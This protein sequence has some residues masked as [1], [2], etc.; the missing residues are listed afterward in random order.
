MRNIFYYNACYY[1]LV[2]RLLYYQKIRETCPKCEKA[3]EQVVE[4]CIA[5]DRLEAANYELIQKS[6][7]FIAFF[8]PS[9]EKRIKLK[10]NK[11]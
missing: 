2:R 5:I 4:N 7:F 3:D 9:I 8:L 1:V 6:L 11:P 10:A